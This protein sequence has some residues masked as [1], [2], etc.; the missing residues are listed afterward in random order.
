MTKNR[1]NKYG[2]FPVLA[3]SATAAVNAL[4]VQPITSEGD[5]N[6][7]LRTA[8]R[9]QANDGERT[10][11]LERSLYNATFTQNCDDEPD[12]LEHLSLLGNAGGGWFVV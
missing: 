2:I 5:V 9:K 8:A 12:V 4:P 7:D 10:H 11:L 1:L 3:L 6:Q